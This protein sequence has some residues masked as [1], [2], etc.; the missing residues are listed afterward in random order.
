MGYSLASRCILWCKEED[1]VDHVFF[2]CNLA[3]SL[4][5]W[6]LTVASSQ[7][8]ISFSASS[9][10]LTLTKGND[11]EGAKLMA[12]IFLSVSHAIW[13]AINVATFEA[14]SSPFNQI[15]IHLQENLS[16]SLQKIVKTYNSPQLRSLTLQLGIP[17]RQLHLD[18]DSGFQPF[19][20]SSNLFLRWLSSIFRSL[21]VSWDVAIFGGSINP[22]FLLFSS[23]AIQLRI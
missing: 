3:K 20:A 2:S 10:W 19:W 22:C 4:W 7:T 6:I 8:P 16:F 13:K 15:K 9:I 17:H 18:Q 23:F 14:I 1:S 21:F 11:K 5:R 12:A